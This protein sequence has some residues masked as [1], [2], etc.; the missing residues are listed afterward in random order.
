MDTSA[1]YALAS[2]TDDMHAQA[3]AVHDELKQA[4]ARLLTTN[5]VVLESV[6]LLQRRIGIREAERFGDFVTTQVEVVWIDE[7]QH[8]TA[9]I[10]WKRSRLRGLSLVDCSSFAVMRDLGVQQAFA[11]DPQFRTA[12]FRLLSGPADRVAERR[13]VYRAGY[14]SRSP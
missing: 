3:V 2:A 4:T 9:W 13:A 1:F 10:L 8:R 12:G 5:Y 11:F 7:A 14:R 6:S